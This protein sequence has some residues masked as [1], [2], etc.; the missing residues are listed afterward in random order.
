MAEIEFTPENE[1]ENKDTVEYEDPTYED[2]IN[3][4][5]THINLLEAQVLVKE[6][7]VINGDPVYVPALN[8]RELNRVKRSMMC[9]FNYIELEP[10][11]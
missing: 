9:W 7:D 11:K 8:T 6:R 3:I 10:I 5:N 1:N 4:I 2:C